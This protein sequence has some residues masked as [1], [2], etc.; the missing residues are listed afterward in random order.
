MK[1]SEVVIKLNKLI[2][3]HGDLDV[4]SCNP[5]KDYPWLVHIVLETKL[6]MNEEK[7]ACIS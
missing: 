6:G 2:E 5:A 4:Y 3:K 1:A 7:I